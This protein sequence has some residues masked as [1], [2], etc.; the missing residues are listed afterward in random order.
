MNKKNGTTEIRAEMERM[1]GDVINT[2]S[3]S[4][5][6]WRGGYWEQLIVH[7]QKEEEEDVELIVEYFIILIRKYHLVHHTK[8]FL[9]ELNIALVLTMKI[10]LLRPEV[11]GRPMITVVLVW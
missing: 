7:Y 3:Q 1:P 9:L 4:I 10:I 6:L 11:H 8:L 5:R 2:Q